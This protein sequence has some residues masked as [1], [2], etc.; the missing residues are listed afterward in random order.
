M[1]AVAA[2]AGAGIVEGHLQIVVPEEP[3]ESRPRVFAPAALPCCAIGL[4]ESG[5]GGTGFYGLLVEAS[6][7]RFLRVEAVGSDGM[8]A[9]LGI[10]ILSFPTYAG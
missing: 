9:R 5:N 6:L 7:F 2:P 8:D 1:Q 3:I 10:R 4:Q